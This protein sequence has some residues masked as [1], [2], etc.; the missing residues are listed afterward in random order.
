M[1]T[2][3]DK[4]DGTLIQ[5]QI[6][7][8]TYKVRGEEERAYIE[9]LARYVDSKMKSISA[10][11]NTSDSLKIAILAA[12]NIADEYFKLERERKD[13]DHR[14]AE[15]AHQLASALDEVLSGGS[16]EEER[17]DGAVT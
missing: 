8:Q 14:V 5:V 4:E 10:S 16:V 2:R 3:P 15:T 12:L 11:T 1:S 13:A 9:E 7:G 6:F 17:E